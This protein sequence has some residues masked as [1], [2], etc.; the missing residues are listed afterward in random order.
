MLPSVG[1][2]QRPL[3][4]KQGLS[5]KNGMTPTVPSTDMNIEEV[6]SMGGGIQLVVMWF[7]Y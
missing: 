1:F 5:L 6:Y 2:D 7:K 3:L 4:F